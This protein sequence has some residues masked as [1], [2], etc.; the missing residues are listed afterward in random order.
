MVELAVTMLRMSPNYH[1]SCAVKRKRVEMLL[2]PLSIPESE[3]L[4][5]TR[6][7]IANT[8]SLSRCHYLG[9]RP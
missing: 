2:H 4:S 3:K 6:V 8:I 5:E 1:I 7:S 9:R